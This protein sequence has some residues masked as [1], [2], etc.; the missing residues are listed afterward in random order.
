MNDSKRALLYSLLGKLPDRSRPI[1][2]QH[3]SI[4]EKDGYLLETLRL[5]LNGLETVP[6]YF[7]S[8]L[9]SSDPGPTVLYNHAHGGE[10]SIGKSEL[11][12]GRDFM[13]HPSYAD[14]LTRLGYRVLCIDAWCFGERSHSDEMDTFKEMLWK[15]AVLWG[16]MVY[17]S[18]RAMDYLVTR[19]DVDPARI[20]TL[21]MSMGST[22]AW[23]LA[24]LDER[25]SVCIDICCLTDFQSLINQGSLKEHGIYYF[26]P[27]LLNHFSTAEINRLIVPRPHLSLAGIYDP[28]TPAE[29][30]DRI[31]NELRSAYRQAGV[32]N[33]WRLRRYETGHQEVPEM[34]K[35]VLDFLQRY[36]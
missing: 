35:E 2:A 5:D 29:G 13:T 11:I 26:V 27:S 7:I 23:W 8:P 25:I 1:S 12:E 21:G 17:D 14:D 36:L 33:R 4:E 28:L 19:P 10:Y 32:E 22:M 16:M 9:H 30:L 6:A 34:R 3:T 18:L 24:A 20:G 31:D 15:G